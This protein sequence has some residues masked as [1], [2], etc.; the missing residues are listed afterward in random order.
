MKHKWSL[1]SRTH[2]RTVRI[3]ERCGMRRISR[4]EMEGGRMLHWVEFYKGTERVKHHATPICEH[5]EVPA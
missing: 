3:C 5:V 1:N 4:H 2:D